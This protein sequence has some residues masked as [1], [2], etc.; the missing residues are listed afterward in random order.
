[1]TKYRHIALLIEAIALINEIN[2]RGTF[3]YSAIELDFKVDGEELGERV[4][5]FLN[6]VGTIEE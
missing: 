4:K 1:M 6:K 3:Y 2:D 5:A